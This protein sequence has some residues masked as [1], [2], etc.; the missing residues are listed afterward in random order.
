MNGSEYT[1]KFVYA[2]MRNARLVQPEKQVPR[3]QKQAAPSQMLADVV[4]PVGRFGRG[5]ARLV[6]FSISFVRLMDAWG[7]VFAGGTRETGRSLL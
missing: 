6:Q 1:L 4:C 3:R 2:P 7:A 5:S